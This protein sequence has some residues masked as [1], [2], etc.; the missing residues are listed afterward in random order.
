MTVFLSV[1][2]AFL[3]IPYFLG[4]QK[5]NKHTVIKISVHQAPNH[6]TNLKK[7]Y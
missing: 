3:Y 4:T 2:D 1:L 7:R 5:Q 6:P